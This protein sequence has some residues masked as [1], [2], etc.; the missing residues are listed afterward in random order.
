MV[1]N[2]ALNNNKLKLLSDIE[3][4]LK[5]FSLIFVDGE[6]FEKKIISSGRS[7]SVQFL[8]FRNFL[9]NA[10]QGKLNFIKNVKWY[11]K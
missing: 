4:L 8:T 9:I 7:K 10:R 11:M 5:I 2:A 1:L 3:I 6:M